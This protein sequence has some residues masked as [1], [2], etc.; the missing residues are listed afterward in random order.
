MLAELTLSAASLVAHDDPAARGIAW[1][2]T[3]VAAE[4]WNEG[5][6]SVG[7]AVT[8]RIVVTA[9]LAWIE[10][11]RTD[12]AADPATLAQ[13]DA[14]VRARLGR[15]GS[16]LG[17]FANW[18]DGFAALY[19][20]ERELAGKGGRDALERIVEGFEKRQNDEGGWDHGAQ[21]G[22]SFYPSTLIAT[23]NL[24]LV[25]LGLA[26][27][28]GVAVDA[29]VR[30]AG[31]KLLTDVQTESGG[32]PYGGRPYMKG[33]EAGRTCGSVLAFSALGLSDDER[34]TRAARYVERNLESIPEG[35]AS[36]AFHVL[37]GALAFS[38]LGE[39]SA[40]RYDEVILARVRAAQRE[41]GSFGSIVD[42]N[43]D[44]LAIM[45]DETTNRAYV[46]AL[47]TAA[48]LARHS[49]IAAALRPARAISA[50]PPVEPNVASVAPAWTLESG[51]V[52]GGAFAGDHIVLVRRD[53]RLT[54]HDL[55]GGAQTGK[56]ATLGSPLRAEI[57]TLVVDRDLLV[58]DQE[59]DDSPALVIGGELRDASPRP[60]VTSRVALV[61]CRA[62][63]RTWE[64]EIDGRVTGGWIS[65]DDVVVRTLRGAIHV[66][67][68]SDGVARTRIEAGGMLPNV[69]IAVHPDGDVLAAAEAE[70]TCYDAR[71]SR[72]DERERWKRRIRLR[73]LTPPSWTA[74]AF[75]G[76]E[77]F[78]GRTDGALHALDAGTG[79]TKW[80]VKLRSSVRRLA[81][82]GA[83]AFALGWDGKVSAV[84]SAKLVWTADVDRGFETHA[85]PVLRATGG[86]VWAVSPATRA[87]VALDARD[88][89]ELARIAA[90]ES[91][92]VATSGD[93]L[94]VM[95]AQGARLHR[96]RASR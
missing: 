59:H 37:V 44:E 53:G 75:T 18:T 90:S 96:V 65:G 81:C 43:P 36:T 8:K 79:E 87:V 9:L 88:G 56:E 24:A 2:E 29:E 11:M 3:R 54:L 94:L 66:L 49:K 68:R 15:R 6:E 84:E 77:Y 47:S 57:G 12:R 83:R 86:I 92:R 23:T 14:S 93:A 78:A 71:T 91:A 13:L 50:P 62:G 89:R 80:E 16:A 60:A 17:A 95:D 51:D 32:L 67:R 4:R 31:L 46:T 35:H 1:L 34:F 20:H 69:A 72:A 42:G 22:V 52:A 48:L 64:R 30:D 26:Q 38:A 28:A 45:A 39:K 10:L 27:R 41:D 19:F 76:R 82:E 85:E 21:L 5:G 73:G 70:L 74:L 55:A 33:V 58:W 7:N 40:A 61:E 25:A 63:G